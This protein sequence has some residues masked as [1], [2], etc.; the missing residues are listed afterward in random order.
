MRAS[1]VSFAHKLAAA[2]LAALLTFTLVPF[3]H[4]DGEGANEGGTD[5]VA[6]GLPDQSTGSTD[7]SGEPQEVSAEQDVAGSPVAPMLASGLA[8]KPSSFINSD[9]ALDGD[10][11]IGS[12]TADGLTFAVA[13]GSTV[14]LVGV[15]G[16]E[17]AFGSEV[18]TSPQPPSAPTP[19]AA[20]LVLPETVA[21]EGTEYTLASIAPYAFYLSGVTDLTLP[22]SVNDVDD[23]AFRSSD[24]AS[25]TVAE[26]NPTYSSFDGAL[27]DADQLSLLLIPEG[28][29]GTVRIPK[30]AEVAGASVFSHCPL[31]DSIFVDAGSA[32]FASENGLLY[33]SDLTTLLRVPAGATEITIRDGCT[34]IAA[35]ALEACAKL[36]TINAPASVTSISPDIFHAI[37]TVSL[38]VASAQHDEAANDTATD[39]QLVA[40]VT[41]FA[42]DESLPEVDPSAITANLAEDADWALWKSFGFALSDA[43]EPSAAVDSFASY[44][45][46]SVFSCNGGGNTVYPKLSNTCGGGTA[47]NQGTWGATTYSISRN[48]VRSETVGVTFTFTNP[49]CTWVCWGRTS[50]ATSGINSGVYTNGGNFYA[51]WNIPITWDANGGYWDDA[52]SDVAVKTSM[53]TTGSAVTGYNGATAPSRKG[54]R[55]VGWKSG[56]TGVVTAAGENV[57]ISRKVTYVAQWGSDYTIHFDGNVIDDPEHPATVPDDIPAVRDEQVDLPEPTRFGYIFKGWATHPFGSTANGHK[58][59]APGE[60]AVNLTDVPGDTVTLYALWAL[61]YDVNVPIC[62]PSDM[63]FALDTTGTGDV[64]AIPAD[65]EGDYSFED[66]SSLPSTHSAAIESRMAVPVA[67]ESVSA[68]AVEGDGFSKVLS[69]TDD[70]PADEQLSF[71]VASGDAKASVKA[72]ESKELAGLMVPEASEATPVAKLSLSYGLELADTAVVLANDGKAAVP[73]AKVSYTL[74]VIDGMAS[75]WGFFMLDGGTP[76]TP[77]RIKAAADDIA[78]ADHAGDV[79]SSGYYG[80]FRDALDAR[81]PFYLRVDDQPDGGFSVHEMDLLGIAQD[82]LSTARKDGSGATIATKAGLTFGWRDAY[83]WTGYDVLVVAPDAPL[84]TSM[85][86]SPTNAGGWS[87]SDM[88]ERLRTTM[89]ERLPAVLTGN[90]GI[91]S[92]RKVS[93]SYPPSAQTTDDKLFLLS[94]YEVT[95]TTRFN[96]KE[97]SSNSFQYQLYAKGGMG[98]VNA[99]FDKKYRDEDDVWCWFR[100]TR[101]DANNG[102]LAIRSNGRSQVFSPATTH[103]GI[104]PCFAI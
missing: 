71:T 45:A 2:A 64:R 103:I 42:T 4:A 70:S 39:S 27:Y 9:V 82:T 65:Y 25:V 1:A 46:I 93:Q 16:A 49:G 35:G 10:P 66:M 17:G 63:T 57:P 43:V 94:A 60:K 62:S 69:S 19:E 5:N 8:G 53:H 96:P 44:A 38:P 79:A 73:V 77:T 101:T 31:A 40:V 48:V 56:E 80:A 81:T 20:N 6:S 30:T 102:F 15:A 84:P 32:A 98:E 92:V 13:E 3:A 55:F 54:Y 72:G 41:L 99:I 23:R 47:D 52:G 78:E 83:S 87:S 58:V 21:Y 51:I 89:A 29:Q 14:E 74:D 24:V 100:S 95:G 11:V 36:A 34:T 86:D 7:Y 90:E 88:R 28:K 76:V 91:V 33:T 26:G 104:A 97:T 59:L 75:K 50:N 22:A 68:S 61:K 85:N 37:P 18:P 12:F 67:V